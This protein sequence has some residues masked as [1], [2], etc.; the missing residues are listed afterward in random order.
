MGQTG[1]G[2]ITGCEGHTAGMKYDKCQS[3]LMNRHTKCEDVMKKIDAVR[4]WIK[5]SC[6]KCGANP[7]QEQFYIIYV[8]FW[9]WQ[10]QMNKNKGKS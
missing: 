5:F 3:L 8:G 2:L 4:E 10:E 9:P 6:L 7:N 1:I